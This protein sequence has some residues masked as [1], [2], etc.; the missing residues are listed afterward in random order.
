MSFSACLQIIW[1]RKRFVSLVLDAERL[2]IF[3]N[4]FKAHLSSN[5][6]TDGAFCLCSA[7]FHLYFCTLPQ[8]LRIR[9][10]RSCTTGNRRGSVAVTT[11]SVALVRHYGETEFVFIN[12]RLWAGQRV[13]G[14]QYIYFTMF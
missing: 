3:D 5:T 2:K 10:K 9:T 14:S 1:I 7:P 13:L 12:F 11:R 4:S 8:S 6:D